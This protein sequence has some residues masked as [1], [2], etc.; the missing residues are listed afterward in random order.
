MLILVVSGEL[1][2][3]ATTVSGL[4]N[5]CLDQVNVRK[6]SVNTGMTI[7]ACDVKAV[8]SRIK[9]ETARDAGSSSTV[10]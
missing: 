6:R 3:N 2:N 1:S 8:F 9:K 4:F 5:F 10:V 7:F